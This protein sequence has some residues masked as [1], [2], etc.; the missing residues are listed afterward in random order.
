[1]GIGC[2][3]AF[4]VTIE[5]NKDLFIPNIFTPN[6]D[7][8]NDVFYIRN[9]PLSGVELVISNRWGN[10]VYKSENYQNDWDAENVEDGVYFYFLK[11]GEEVKKGWVEIQRGVKPGN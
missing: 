2:E 3:Y 8:V 4:D 5:L 6:N 11:I 7:G 10:R 1:D 9:N